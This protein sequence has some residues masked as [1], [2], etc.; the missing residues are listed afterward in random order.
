MSGMCTDQVV[1]LRRLIGEAAV[2]TLHSLQSTKEQNAVLE[3][4]AYAAKCAD[5]ELKLIYITPGENK[6]IIG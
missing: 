6:I 2:Q 5:P 1:A 3:Q 4:L